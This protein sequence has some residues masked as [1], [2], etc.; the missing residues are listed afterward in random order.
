MPTS[1][2]QAEPAPRVAWPVPRCW[3]A[4]RAWPA[5]AAV[6]ALL[7]R[8]AT[9]LLSD[10]QRTG[11]IS[12]PRRAVRRR[13]RRRCRRA[14]TSSSPRRACGPT[15]RCSSTRSG[16]GSTCSARSSSPG[17]CARPAPRPG[18]RSPART[19]RPRRCACSKSML[20]AA[21]LRALAVGN[22]G[23][24]GDRRGDGRASPYDVLAVELSSLPTA[25]VVDDHPGRRGTAQPR[26][27]S[28][29]LARLD[30][31]LRR[32]ED[33]GVGRTRS[34]SATPTTPSVA[35]LLA[36]RAVGARTSAFTLGEPGR[37][38]L[39]VRG[40]V[41]VDRAFGAD[42]RRCSPPREVRPTG[43][44]NVAN[45]LAAAALARA[46]GLGAERDRRRPAGVRPRSAPQP[47]RARTSAASTTS[48]T[49]RRPTRTRR[50]RR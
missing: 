46:Y 33:Q 21:G 37:G 19:A 25:L 1:S 50:R 20:Q 47:V 34:P 38:Q 2:T 9:V 26:S 4:A 10:R 29:R 30:A 16:A 40:G 35:A 49:A 23:R 42:R 39:G 12:R 3:S 17:G 6:R 14:S 44:H 45:A 36:P 31:G 22:V 18:S 13:A 32:G 24:L 28:P 5:A 15:T 8:G 27:R 11:A 41:L 48:T 43:S 7:A